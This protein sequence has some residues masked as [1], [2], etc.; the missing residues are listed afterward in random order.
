MNLRCIESGEM[1]VEGR[2]QFVFVSC[3]PNQGFYKGGLFRGIRVVA[4]AVQNVISDFPDQV[5][6]IPDEEVDSLNHPVWIR[7]LLGS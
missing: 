4:L 1:A 3:I 6:S 7:E 5:K 2:E